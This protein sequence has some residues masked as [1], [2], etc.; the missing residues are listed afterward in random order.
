MLFL[1]NYGFISRIFVQLLDAMFLA[2]VGELSANQIEGL[3]R[4]VHM[5]IVIAWFRRDKGKSN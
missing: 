5:F 3:F 1:I 2:S 4:S